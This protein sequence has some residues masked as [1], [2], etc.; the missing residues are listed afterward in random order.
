MAAGSAWM[1]WATTV[2]CFSNRRGTEKVSGNWLSSAGRRS[3]D[4][5][6]TKESASRPDGALRP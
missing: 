5:R 2:M 1:R 3:N 4:T 6:M